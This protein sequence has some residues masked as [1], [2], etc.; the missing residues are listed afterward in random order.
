MSKFP[1]SDLVS[2][3]GKAIVEGQGNDAILI[4]CEIEDAVAILTRKA[5]MLDET[6]EEVERLIQNHGTNRRT[7]TPT[8]VLVPASIWNVFLRARLASYYTEF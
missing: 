6:I 7:K 1:I 4:G 8:I 3:Y 5:A 2:S